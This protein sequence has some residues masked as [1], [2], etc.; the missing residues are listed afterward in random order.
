MWPDYCSRETLAKRL[1]I[2]PEAVD[3]YV[4]RE[5]IPNPIKLGEALLWRWIDVDAQ[6]AGV[7]NL[8]HN[9]DK[10]SE[11]PYVKGPKSARG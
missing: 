8:R 10:A 11:D 7:S 3:Q 9:S 5:L 1:D 6:I 4:K 2:K